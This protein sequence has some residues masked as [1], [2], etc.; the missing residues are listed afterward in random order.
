MNKIDKLHYGKF[1]IYYQ[2]YIQKDDFKRIVSKLE[3]IVHNYLLSQK[4]SLHYHLQG[5][6]SKDQST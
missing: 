5:Q 3:N 6:A 4:V 1:I 2:K